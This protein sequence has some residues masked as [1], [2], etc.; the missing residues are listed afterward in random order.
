VIIVLGTPIPVVV[1]N[2]STFVQ[3]A[4]SVLVS[5]VGA[6]RKVCCVDVRALVSR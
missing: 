3:L 1:V 5:V 2:I 6:D 4:V